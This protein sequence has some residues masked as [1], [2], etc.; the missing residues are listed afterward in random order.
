MNKVLTGRAVRVALAAAIATAGVAL[1]AGAANASPAG[2]CVPAAIFK[3]EI[4]W[5]GDHAPWHSDADLSL[6]LQNRH[7]IV[8]RTAVPAGTALHWSGPNG[9][10][11]ITVGAANT[12]TGTAQFPNEGPVGYRGTL[13]PRRP[14]QCAPVGFAK[15]EIQWGGDQAPWHSDAPLVALIQNR[16][17]VVDR[18]TAPAGTKLS[19]TGPNGNAAIAVGGGKTF[20]GTAQ[21]P[22]EGPVGYRGTF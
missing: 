16:H 6:V 17:T 13:D 14:R 15:T 5:G 12:F 3:T 10:A 11:D 22:N 2:A 20:A 21:F 4:Q 1:G 7:P 18:A 8:D 19:W 9:N